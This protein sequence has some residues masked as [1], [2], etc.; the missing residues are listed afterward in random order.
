M[1]ASLGGIFRPATAAIAIAAL[2]G[3]QTARAQES[4]VSISVYGG[5]CSILI[6]GDAPSA[7]P[8]IGTLMVDGF[9]E[10]R[11]S[12]IF[13]NADDEAIAFQAIPLQGEH[14]G[15]KA[16]E[17]NGQTMPATGTCTM[18]LDARNTGEIRCEAQMAGHVTSGTF[19]VTALNH[20]IGGP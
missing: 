10:G 11:K 7:K 20:S 13:H 8:C 12:V 5:T 1:P 16:V 4:P 17:V 6:V 19:Q 18:H 15:V 3:A 2:S 9:P 14:F